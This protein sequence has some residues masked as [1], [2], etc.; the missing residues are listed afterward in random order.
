MIMEH[1]SVKVVFA[2]E[3]ESLKLFVNKPEKLNV[4]W[5]FCLIV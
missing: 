1:L 5:S 4:R 3:A 2:V